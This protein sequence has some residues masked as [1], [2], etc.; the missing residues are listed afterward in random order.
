ML[1]YFILIHIRFLKTSGG[2]G[3]VRIARFLWGLSDR[4]HILKSLSE[5]IDH[6]SDTCACGKLPEMSATKLLQ[7]RSLEAR[8]GQRAMIPTSLPP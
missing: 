5:I 8:A 4:F 2:A 3:I 6:P 7:T 1:C